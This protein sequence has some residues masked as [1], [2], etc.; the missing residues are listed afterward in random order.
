M[1]DSLEI[2]LPNAKNK[3][4]EIFEN[5][6]GGEIL[7]L[8]GPLGSGKTTFAQYLAKNLKIKDTVTSP[9]FVIMNRYEGILKKK[10]IFLFHLDLYRVHDFEEVKALG[11]TEAWGR[12]DTVTVIE[13]ADKIR[14]HLPESTKFYN[15]TSEPISL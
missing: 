3:A 14:H 15:F 5:L 10:Q 6:E 9:T 1:K 8:T 12:P 4:Q 2:K 11:I 7:A 13:W